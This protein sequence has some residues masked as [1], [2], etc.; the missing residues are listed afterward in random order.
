MFDSEQL[1]WRHE[2]VVK[3]KRHWS[4]NSIFRAGLKFFY[5]DLQVSKVIYPPVWYLR[6]ISQV[7]Q[8]WGQEASLKW[9]KCIGRDWLSGSNQ[10]WHTRHD[11]KPLPDWLLASSTQHLRWQQPRGVP[12][13]LR[14]TS[15][16]DIQIY[17]RHVALPHCY[18][19]AK[20]SSG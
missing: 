8:L 16:Q 19:S 15:R 9:D 10:S 7:V 14:I 17:T 12:G 13:L 11:R 20:C 5:K 3:V 2:V 6:E 4:K 18:A 1:T